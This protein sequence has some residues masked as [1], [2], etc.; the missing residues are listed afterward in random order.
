MVWHPETNLSIASTLSSLLRKTQI[1][2]WVKPITDQKMNP[3]ENWPVHRWPPGKS[4]TSNQSEHLNAVVTPKWSI[5]FQH[6]ALGHSGLGQPTKANSHWSVSWSV[7]H[8][9]RTTCTA[10]GKIWYSWL[11]RFQYRSK[12]RSLKH[13]MVYDSKSKMGLGHGQRTDPLAYLQAFHTSH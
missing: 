5:I 1:W 6:C 9:R 12:E 13:C 4:E 8:S 2:G 3:R 11:G 10:I 7:D